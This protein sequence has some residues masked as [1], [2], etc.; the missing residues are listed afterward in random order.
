MTLSRKSKSEYVNNL[1]EK[2]FKLTKDFVNPKISDKV[3][4][5]KSHI[6]L[7]VFLL[8]HYKLRITI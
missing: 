1:Y 4:T 5:L 7:P 2:K 6:F 8:A 3:P